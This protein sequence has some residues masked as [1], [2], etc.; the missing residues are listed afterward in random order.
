M[1]S[2]PPMYCKVHISTLHTFF[3]RHDNFCFFA[4]LG[5]RGAPLVLCDGWRMHATRGCIL[6]RNWGQKSSDFCSLLVTAD[7][8][9]LYS[10]LGLEIP[11]TIAESGLGLCFVYKQQLAMYQ[12]GGKPDKQL[13]HLYCFRNT[14]KTINQ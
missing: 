10:F 5:K 1:I 11:K 13:Y 4:K 2:T 14:Y 8:T 6:G 3:F 7:F 9:P 12:K